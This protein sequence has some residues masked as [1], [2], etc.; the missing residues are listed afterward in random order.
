MKVVSPTAAANGA[1]TIPRL[2]RNHPAAGSLAPK[3][4][5]GHTKA[6]FFN[7]LG[8]TA[9]RWEELQAQLLELVLHADAE[10]VE[11][12]PFGQKYEVRGIIRGPN[13]RIA[14]VLTTRIIRDGEHRPRLVTAIPV[15]ST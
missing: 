8:F 9:S 5:V 7:R 2:P 14:G 3:R 13:G 6:R 15:A 12:T 1:W 11:T 10:M 4:P